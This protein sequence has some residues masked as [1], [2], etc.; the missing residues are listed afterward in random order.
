MTKVWID[1]SITGGNRGA[2]M[3]PI[4]NMPAYGRDMSV[5]VSHVANMALL[6]IPQADEMAIRLTQVGIDFYAISL[7]NNP[8]VHGGGFGHGRKWPILFAGIMLDNQDMQNPPLYFSGSTTVFKFNTDRYT[9]YG[10]PTDQYPNGKP[11]WGTDC[12]NGDV[13]ECRTY[14]PPTDASSDYHQC[15]SV[16]TWVGQA[17]AARIMNAIEIWNHDAF[18]DYVDRWVSEPESWYYG[19]T[20]RADV[21]CYGGAFIEDM[22]NAYR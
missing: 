15:C 17:L 20:H 16:L 7:Q 21:Y 14:D 3:H 19:G 13:G 5:E 6:G 12:E 8:Y 22:W 4:W 9:S 2:S 1:H 18:F 11:I 10:A